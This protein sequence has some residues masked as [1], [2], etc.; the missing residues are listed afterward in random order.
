MPSV[1]IARARRFRSTKKNETQ[2]ASQ[3]NAEAM[4][5]TSVTETR[6]ASP[7]SRPAMVAAAIPMIASEGV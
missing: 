7:K 2:A 6:S 4:E 1:V 3:P 5:P